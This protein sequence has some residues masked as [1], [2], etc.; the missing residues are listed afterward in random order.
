MAQQHAWAVA[1]ILH[2]QANKQLG[3]LRVDKGPGHSGRCDYLDRRMGQ[4]CPGPSP[5]L[6]HCSG[7]RDTR[8]PGLFIRRA[9]HRSGRYHLTVGRI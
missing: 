1:A 6:T 8:P 2:R 5:V 4:L 7:G 9:P 3:E